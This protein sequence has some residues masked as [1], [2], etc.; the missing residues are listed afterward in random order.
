MPVQL[1]L[2]DDSGNVREDLKLPIGHEDAES[3]ARQIQAQWDEGKELVLTV[4]MSMG[5][6]QVNA[7]KEAPKQD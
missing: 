2:M 1:G 7:T 4:L 5:E 6:E 3:L